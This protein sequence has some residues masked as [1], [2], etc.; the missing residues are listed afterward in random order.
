VDD[1]GAVGRGHRPGQRLDKFRRLGRGQRPAVEPA[2]DVAAAAELQREERQA[3][4]FAD[5]INLDDV[6]VLHAGEGLGFG[7]EPGQL[8]RGRVPA[9]QDHFQGDR[10][11]QADLPR[12]VDHA[13]PAAT[14]FAKDLVPRHRQS[15]A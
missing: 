4:V 9:G 3:V 12:F 2:G 7:L 1:A 5:L 15:L 6:G 10:P 13:H 11:V 14:E 8:P